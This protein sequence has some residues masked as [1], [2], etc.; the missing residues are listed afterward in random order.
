MGPPWCQYS[1]Q[2]VLF[3]CP[4]VPIL[5]FWTPVG[6]IEMPAVRKGMF[7][8]DCGLVS[9]CHREALSATWA[10]LFAPKHLSGAMG[11]DAEGD[12]S[13]SVCFAGVGAWFLTKPSSTGSTPCAFGSAWRGQTH[14]GVFG[15]RLGKHYEK[16]SQGLCFGILFKGLGACVGPANK[17][18]RKM[19][20]KQSTVAPGGFSVDFCLPAG[21]PNSDTA[22]W[23]RDFWCAGKTSHAEKSIAKHWVKH[24]FGNIVQTGA[25]R[26]GEFLRGKVSQ[27]RPHPLRLGVK[28]L[29]SDSASQKC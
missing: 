7:L 26:K 20:L 10:P 16:S 12:F 11:C 5:R 4:G 27:G 18:F 22:A 17:F 15:K 19:M 28:A 23:G 2:I 29:W 9:G 6:G 25:V 1:S 13:G 21:T 14:C 24:Y 8:L 3:G